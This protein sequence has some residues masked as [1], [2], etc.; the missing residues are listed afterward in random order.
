[1]LLVDGS[2][3]AGV[4]LTLWEASPL[5]LSPPASML[6]T[7][8]VDGI[9]DMVRWSG[10]EVST[11]ALPVTVALSFYTEDA[12]SS[13]AR[14]AFDAA[15]LEV[16]TDG[17]GHT[18][19]LAWAAPPTPWWSPLG[20]RATSSGTLAPWSAGEWNTIA[21]EVRS[22][23]VYAPDGTRV[24]AVSGVAAPLRSLALGLVD[25]HPGAVTVRYDDITI[26]AV[27]CPAH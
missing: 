20:G 8:P 9:E 14:L 25:P 15:V 24:A 3:D 22:D 1:M 5:A 21:F 26:N 17:P 12:P 18:V 23:G 13:I 27:S 19:A 6:I 11:P 10:L 16:R 4:T 2:K 7:S